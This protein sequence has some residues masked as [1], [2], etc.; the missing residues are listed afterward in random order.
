MCN[1]KFCRNYH[2]YIWATISECGCGCHQV[3]TP[4]GHDG[5][6]CE[7]PNGY[8]SDNPYKKLKPAIYYRKIMDKWQKECNEHERE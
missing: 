6:C 5:L 1:C 7:F 2:R 8:K 3:K 4:T